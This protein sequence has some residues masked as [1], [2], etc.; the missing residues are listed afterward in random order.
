MA[1]LEASA[2]GE[3]RQAIRGEV[4]AAGDTGYD[5][6]RKIWNGYFDRKP[7]AIARCVRAEDVARGNFRPRPRFTAFRQRRRT[8]FCGDRS[9]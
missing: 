9:R 1:T 7:A 2:L 5:A 4:L 3:L 8:Q 6:A